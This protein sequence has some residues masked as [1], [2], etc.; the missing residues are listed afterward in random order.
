MKYHANRHVIWAAYLQLEPRNF[1]RNEEVEK[2]KRTTIS[3]GNKFLKLY[4]REIAA[5]LR[6]VVESGKLLCVP[7]YSRVGPSMN[8]CRPN[9]NGNRQSDCLCVRTCTGKIKVKPRYPYSRSGKLALF[10]YRESRTGEQ[11]DQGFERL[12]QFCQ[13]VYS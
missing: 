9:G 1:Q 6:E 12:K 11:P 2:R 13:V 4:L 8:Y 3:L 10:S 7:Y 5:T